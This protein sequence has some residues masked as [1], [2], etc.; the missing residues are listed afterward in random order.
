MN[1]NSLGAKTMQL[2]GAALTAGQL[3][4]GGTYQMVYDGTNLQISGWASPASGGGITKIAQVV[5]ASSATVITFSSIPATFETLIAKFWGRSTGAVG[6]ILVY[7]KLNTDNNSGNYVGP[8]QCVGSGAATAGGGNVATS[9][10]GFVFGCP[11]TTGNANPLATANIEIGSYAR[12]TFNKLCVS[13]ET[14]Q[15]GTNV[16]GVTSFQWLNTTAV[17]R[18][19]LT[20]ASGSFADGSVCTLYGLS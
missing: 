18:I 8:Q 4:A 7:M 11:G 3:I 2:N 19:D 20:I 17:N 1:F 5:T 12:T 14:A 10:G 13:Q 16:V 9:N 6:N 15:S